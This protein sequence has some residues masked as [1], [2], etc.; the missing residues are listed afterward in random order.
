L[1]IEKWNKRKK[2]YKPGVTINTTLIEWR[3]AR[4]AFLDLPAG[5]AGTRDALNRLADAEDA[6]F[7]IS[8][9]ISR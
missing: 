1:A 3:R 8:A 2:R 4:R 6:L 5:D 9:G 7:R